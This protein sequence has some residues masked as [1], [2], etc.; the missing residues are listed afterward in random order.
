M[1]MP[2]D[3][4]V[5]SIQIAGGVCCHTQMASC[6]A[7]AHFPLGSTNPNQPRTAKLLKV[8]LYTTEEYFLTM[9]F[10]DTSIMHSVVI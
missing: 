5:V 6:N 1:A 7:N 2:N 10:K 4:S 9:I 3:L 8:L